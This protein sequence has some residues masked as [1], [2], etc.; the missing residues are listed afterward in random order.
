MGQRMNGHG[1]Q[2]ASERWRK[3]TIRLGHGVVRAVP[4]SALGS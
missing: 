2:V 3:F 1:T 4:F